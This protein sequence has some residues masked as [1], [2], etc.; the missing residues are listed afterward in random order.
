MCLT[1]LDHA[2]TMVMDSS[3]FHLIVNHVCE[4]FFLR[5]DGIECSSEIMK[6]SFRYS[7][8]YC[9]GDTCDILLIHIL[10][11]LDHVLTPLALKS[12][13]YNMFQI[14]PILE[15][16]GALLCHRCQCFILLSSQVVLRPRPRE[17][18]LRLR[19]GPS[20]VCSSAISWGSCD[21]RHCEQ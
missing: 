2:E 17:E 18:R 9:E 4:F 6:A 11:K 16:C 21:V 7:L 1:D 12:C 15:C 13:S 14:M 10:L 19:C 5:L 20:S 8:T 3:N